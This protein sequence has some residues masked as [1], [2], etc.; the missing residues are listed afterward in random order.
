MAADYLVSGLQPLAID[1]AAPCSKATFLALCREQLGERHARAIESAMDGAASAP[2]CDTSLAAAWRDLDAQ[3]R[4]AVAAE[5]ARTRGADPSRW[6]RPVNGCSLYWAG[7]VQA[8]FQEK[9]PSRRD[10]MLDQ[11]RWEAAGELTP[12]ASPL[13]AAAAYT[14]GIRLAIVLRRQALSAEAGNATFD[15]LTAASKLEF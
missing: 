5:R 8:A 2:E 12:P 14:Y 9:D 7:R 11:V 13:S 6:R 15:A 3:L 1:G 10:H 4:N